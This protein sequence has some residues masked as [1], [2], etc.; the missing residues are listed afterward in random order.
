MKMEK[1]A[2]I[3][4]VVATLA[5]FLFGVFDPSLQIL[6][7]FIIMDFAT[8]VLFALY[9]GELSSKLGYRGLIRKCGIMFVIIIAQ[10][11]DVLTGQP[12]FR[13]P[14]VY[15]FIAIEGVSILENLGKMGVPIPAILLDKLSQL[16][17]KGIVLSTETT[18][19]TTTDSTS[20]IVIETTVEEVVKEAK[21][22]KK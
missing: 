13:I 11:L 17:E 19:T 18:V 8:G 6:A 20:D 14:I 15:F 7:T 1:F 12:L 2:G 22:P 21:V 4:S 9:S 16:K 3:F 5:T 10:L